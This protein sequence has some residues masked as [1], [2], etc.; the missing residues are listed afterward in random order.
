MEDRRFECIMLELRLISGIE[1]KRFKSRFGADIYELYTAVINQLIEGGFLELTP[2]S[3]KLT[4]RGLDVAD[5]VILKFM[6]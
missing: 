1:R 2:V 3:L 4:E 6:D 5:S